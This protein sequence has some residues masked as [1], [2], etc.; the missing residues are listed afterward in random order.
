M[1]DR[2]AETMRGLARRLGYDS[3]EIDG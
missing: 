1:E 2:L 3:I